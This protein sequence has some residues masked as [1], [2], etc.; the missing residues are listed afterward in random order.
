MLR[1]SKVEDWLRQAPFRQGLSTHGDCVIIRSCEGEDGRRGVLPA[2]GVSGQPAGSPAICLHLMMIPPGERGMPHLHQG[3]ESAIYA[4]S[5][6]TEIWHGDDLVKR[7]VMRP[8]DFMYVPPDTPH[9]PVNRSDVMA[10]AVVATSGAGEHD[11]MIVV[12]LP[13]HL[14]DLLSL[15]VAPQD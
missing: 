14:A 2:D 6:E 15:P 13:R 3:H 4:V 1:V 8:G 7:T 9:L 12:G 10:I 5:G 11:S